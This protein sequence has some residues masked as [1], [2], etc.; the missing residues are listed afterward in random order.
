MSALV[1]PL[2]SPCKSQPRAARP[3]LAQFP[4]KSVC[5]HLHHAIGHPHNLLVRKC[6]VRPL[7]DQPERKA[8]LP[9]RDSPT[10][11]TV[12]DVC[13][14]EMWPSRLTDGL[15]DAPC[16]PVAVKQDG[17]VPPHRGLVGDLV[18]THRLGQ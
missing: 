9:L 12:K 7:E 14:H 4:T 18:E 10:L 5:Q 15:Q 11:V 13:G 6:A 8:Y 2:P 3:A 1:I 17:D 16:G